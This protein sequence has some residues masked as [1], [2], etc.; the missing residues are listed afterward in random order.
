MVKEAK[1][2]NSSTRLL[3]TEKSLVFEKIAM[4]IE[5]NI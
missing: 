5:R 4:V 2:S 3:S 1:L